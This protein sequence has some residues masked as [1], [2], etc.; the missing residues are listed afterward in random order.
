[1]KES[2]KQRAER[3]R[4]EYAELKQYYPSVKSSL[5]WDNAFQLVV[6]TVLSAQTTDKRVNM[7]TPR[8]FGTYPEPADL[9]VAEVVKVEEIIYELGFY[10]SKAR[11]IVGLAQELCARFD[12]VV[13]QTMEELVT[14]PGVGRKTASLVLAEYFRQPGLPVDTHVTR[15]TKRLHWTDQWN[16][17]NPDVVKIEKQIARVFPPEDWIGISHRLIY[18]GREICH[19]HNPECFRCPLKDTCPSAPEFI[20][21]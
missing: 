11:H 20:K 7:V 12:G 15:L 16:R 14:L 13:P 6:A 3:M 21:K 18:L 2:A 19:P 1:M 4:L 8:L 9:A 5:N 17:K 10:H